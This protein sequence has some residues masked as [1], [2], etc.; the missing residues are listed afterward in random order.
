VNFT[1]QEDIKNAKQIDVIYLPP[2]GLNGRYEVRCFREKGSRTISTNL[3]VSLGHPK[4]GDY[5]FFDKDDE[6]FMFMP[7]DVYNYLKTNLK[8]QCY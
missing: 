5:V 6:I 7:V 8:D 2:F 4:V 1:I 3:V